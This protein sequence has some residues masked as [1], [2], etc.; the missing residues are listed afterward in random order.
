MTEPA[1]VCLACGGSIAL[2]AFPGAVVHCG[3]CG[4]SVQVPSAEP[5]SVGLERSPYRAASAP[6]IEPASEGGLR[7]G[8]CPRCTGAEL[9]PSYDDFQ[10]PRC[11]GLF[12]PHTR[13]QQLVEEHRSSGLRPVPSRPPSE[14]AAIAYLPCPACGVRMNRRNFGD[15]SGIVVDVC[16]EHGVWFDLG[17]L[18]AVLAHAYDL[19][20]DS[21]ARAA[22]VALVKRDL[23]PPRRSESPPYETNPML[24]VANA[25]VDSM[26]TTAEGVGNLLGWLQ[27]LFR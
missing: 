22:L 27:S 5:V 24:R 12:V 25:R 20:E 21:A 1:A 26:V 14:A 4:A 7:G 16:K 9:E 6:P 15:S 2:A 3:R 23:P 19:P 17:E 8:S 10:C 11:S 13:L 18:E